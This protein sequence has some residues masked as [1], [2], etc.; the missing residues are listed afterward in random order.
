LIIYQKLTNTENTGMNIIDI[1]KN[2]LRLV[3]A[4]HSEKGTTAA[5]AKD[6]GYEPSQ[7]SQ[8]LTGQRNMGEKLAREIEKRAKLSEGYLDSDHTSDINDKALEI[9]AKHGKDVRALVERYIAAD[10]LLKSAVLRLL[11]VPQDQI[12]G[13]PQK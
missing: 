7:I 4:N 12:P 3:I 13:Q 2:N 1:R 6:L 11:E 10:P 9:A 5:F 8:I